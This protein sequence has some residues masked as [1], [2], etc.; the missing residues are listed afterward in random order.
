MTRQLTRHFLSVAA[1]V[2]LIVPQFSVAAAR[3]IS[4]VSGPV[5]LP[6]IHCIAEALAVD[7]RGTIIVGSASDVSGLQHAVKRTP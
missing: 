3:R 4:N 1:V 7:A 2:A 6:S 5:T